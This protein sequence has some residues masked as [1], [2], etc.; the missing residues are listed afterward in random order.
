MHI[1]TY[2]KTGQCWCMKPWTKYKLGI[3]QQQVWFKKNHVIF[4]LV[5]FF[6]YPDLSWWCDRRR[7]R[8]WGVGRLP[9]PWASPPGPLL[10]PGPLLPLGPLLHPGCSSH[11]GC[12]QSR[13]GP[14]GGRVGGW[15][16]RRRRP[17]PRSGWGP[18]SRLP[19][20]STTRGP[21]C[22]YWSALDV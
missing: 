2:H 20:R 21:I 15:P 19:P 8:C 5:G 12:S 18:H 14:A 22:S 17:C 6:D 4:L 11:T 3:K 13:S 9:G 1:V 16:G 7:A 10:H